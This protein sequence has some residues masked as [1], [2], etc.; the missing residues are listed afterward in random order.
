VS[1]PGGPGRMPLPR[2]TILLECFLHLHCHWVVQVLGSWMRG[3]TDKVA[4]SACDE[5]ELS[6]AVMEIR[7]VGAIALDM[8]D[9]VG[10]GECMS[11]GKCG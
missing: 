2:H 9:V 5:H 8:R 7:P 4:P 1:W 6:E 3:G 11:G 10:Q